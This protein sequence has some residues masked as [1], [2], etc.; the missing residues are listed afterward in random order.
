M[1]RRTSCRARNIGDSISLNFEK[2]QLKT[3]TARIPPYLSSAQQ[4][5]TNDPQE[6]IVRKPIIAI[7]PVFG[8]LLSIFTLT[9]AHSRSL[10]MHEYLQENDKSH[11]TY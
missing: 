1:A 8:I 5:L 10:L 6:N 3:P 4:Y 2:P 9:P 7:L 11:F